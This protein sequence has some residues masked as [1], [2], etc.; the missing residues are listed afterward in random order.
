MDQNKEN[1]VDKE[2]LRLVHTLKVSTSG[3]FD[4]LMTRSRKN[5]PA[6]L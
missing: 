6:K 4:G 1:E 3:K 2:L 5:T